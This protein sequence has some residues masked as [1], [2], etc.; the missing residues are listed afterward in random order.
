MFDSHATL[1]D[2]NDEFLSSCLQP[3]ADASDN[4]DNEEI[5]Q[6]PLQLQ[7]YNGKRCEDEVIRTKLIEALLQLCTTKTGRN[8]LRRKGV[9]ALLRELDRATE[10]RNADAS[11]RQSSKDLICVMGDQKLRMLDES[12]NSLHRL[13]AMLIRDDSDLVGE[14]R[15]GEMA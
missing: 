3:L 8:A 7:Y 1:L 5:E 9:Y 6:L 12:S 2:E 14:N 15:Y 13:I 11:S 4:L 10:Q